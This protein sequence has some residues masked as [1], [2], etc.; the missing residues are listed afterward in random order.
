MKVRRG[1]A[2]LANH[3]L[4]L[5]IF[6]AIVNI[7]IRGFHYHGALV[8][9]V[10]LLSVQEVVLLGASCHTCAQL[11]AHWSLGLRV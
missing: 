2:A 9:A 5:T 7:I 8:R 10:V 1:L 4:R 6:N 11:G 3:L